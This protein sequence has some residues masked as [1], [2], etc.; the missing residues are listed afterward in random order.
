MSATIVCVCVERKIMKYINQISI[1]ATVSF[2]GELTAH[3]VP[4]PIPGSIYGLVIM[5]ILLVAKVIK[6]EWVKDTAVFLLALMPIMF[7]SALVGIA[8]TYDSWRNLILPILVVG[9]VGTALVM[10]VTGVVSQALINAKEKK[11]WKGND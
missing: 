10:I 9:T 4:L 1:I 11:E 2:A 5:L 8:E 7:V 3:L 6:V